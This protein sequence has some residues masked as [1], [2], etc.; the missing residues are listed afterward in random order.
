M[1]IE[2][3][4]GMTTTT[5]VQ[6]NGIVQNESPTNRGNGYW[7]PPYWRQHLDNI[8]QMRL[9]KDAP[10]DSMGA[11]ACAD[12]QA[13]PA[14]KR[15]QILLALMLSSQTKDNVTYGAMT[16]LRRYGCTVE[17][18]FN[19]SEEKLIELIY[20]VGFYK[21]KAAF[22]KK[23]TSILREKYGDDIPATVEDLCSLPGVGPKMAHLAMDL[24]WEKTSGIGVDT[25][26]HRICNRLGWCRTPTRTPEQTRAAVEAWLPNELW[27][28]VNL[29]MVGF[30]QQICI[31]VKPRCND[32]LNRNICLYSRQ[33]GEQTDGED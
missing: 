9:S 32:C 29:L 33:H 2:D 4:G 16:N 15:Y 5:T 3:C 10:V 11:L 17:N 24:A 13:P 30:G 28:E 19:T 12:P 22:V 21:R 1:D 6:S 7:E 20:P 23:T 26:V 31:P 14:T 8:R 18:I 27:S 25:H